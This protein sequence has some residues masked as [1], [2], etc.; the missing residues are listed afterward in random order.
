MFDNLV[1][2]WSWRSVDYRMYP[3]WAP[4]GGYPSYPC[5]GGG[6]PPGYPGIPCGG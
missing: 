1:K 2:F 3:G 4:G 5:G 6:G